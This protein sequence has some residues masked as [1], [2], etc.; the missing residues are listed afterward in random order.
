MNGSGLPQQSQT[1]GKYEGPIA[2]VLLS[3]LG[4]V[5]W[6][7]FI[8]FFA[9]FWSNG[10]SLFQNAIVTIVSF[11]ISGLLIGLIWMPWYHMTGERR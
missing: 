5:A 10:F 4:I 9:L 6:L 2:P 1:P 11:L 7:V 8:L 3:I